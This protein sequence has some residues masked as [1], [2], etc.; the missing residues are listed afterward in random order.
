VS[1]HWP[2]D[3]AVGPDPS[4]ADPSSSQ[5]SEDETISA[6][7]VVIVGGSRPF[8]PP[9][10]GLDTTPHLTSDH[11]LHLESLPG[12]L[13]IIGGGYISCELAHFFGALGSKITILE[14]ADRLL[15]REDAEVG[16]EFTQR[17]QDRYD[18]HLGARIER[19][20]GDLSSVRIDLAAQDGSPAEPVLADQ[21][22]VATGRRPNSD[23]LHLQNAG[24]NLD[25]RGHVLVNKYLETNQDGVWALGDIIGVLPLKHVA[26]RQARHVIQALFHDSRTPMRYDVIPHAVFSAPQLA[27][28]GRTEEELRDQ[29]IAY[30]VG[31]WRLRDTAM[32]MALREDGLAKILAAPNASILIHE[33]AVPMTMRG[34]LHDT[35]HAHPALSQIVEEACKAALTAPVESP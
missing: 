16:A 8:V 10:P 13:A 3:H 21:I 5:P 20:S 30:K 11:A 7:R 4:N 29:G 26:V 25:A 27:A 22:L 19:V 15:A 14:S 32:S 18:V 6:D 34:S 24:L 1:L 35:V 33:L 17:Y 2:Q 31:R 23:L 9:I 28:V 12:H